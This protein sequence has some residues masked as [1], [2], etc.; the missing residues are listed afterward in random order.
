MANTFFEEARLRR[1]A[2]ERVVSGLPLPEVDM[3]VPTSIED[4]APEKAFPPERTQERDHR[5]EIYERVYRGDIT[6]FV[7]DNTAS[8]LVMNFF[9]RIPTVIV[10]LMLSADPAVP[11]EDL[12]TMQ[13]LLGAGG[14]N[15]FRSGRGYLVRAGE[16]L[17]SPETSCV[18]DGINDDI[19]TTCLGT[20]VESSDY[21]PDYVDVYNVG[22]D[23]AIYW[24]QSY[25]HGTLG[26]VIIPPT[27]M[28]GTFAVVDRPPSYRGWGKSIYDSLL[29]P[30]VGMALRLSGVEWTTEKNLHPVTLIPL[31]V[32]N[33]TAF[34]NQGDPL[35]RQGDTPN[36]AAFQRELNDAFDEDT[37]LFPDGSAAPTKLEWGAGAMSAAMEMVD[38][39]MTN[40]S[41]M[42]GI[43]I[44]VLNGEFAAVS[45]VA[46]DR[47]LLAL[48]AETR[49]FKRVLHAGAEKVYGQPFVWDDYFAGGATPE[50]SNLEPDPPAQT[51]VM[52]PSES[53]APGAIEAV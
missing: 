52:V 9:E 51:L 24:R 39:L 15:G 32:A 46:L 34:G 44:D 48:A 13:A 12:L 47:M 27:S 29:A 35:N 53:E 37:L 40:V 7:V 11:D 5:L 16:D 19:F 50:D 18:H 26:Q 31:A 33:M 30:V 2:R 20:S 28:P 17:W 23:Y 43:P 42:C 36:L 49:M 8:N 10:A 6:D 45:G 22:P 25:D 3:L 4:Y 38:R 14:M 21:N 41:A 1:P